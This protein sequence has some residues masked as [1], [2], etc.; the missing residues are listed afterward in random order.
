MGRSAGYNLLVVLGVVSAV[1]FLFHVLPGD[2]ARL[3]MGQRSDEASVANAR[4]ELHLDRNLSVRYLL[5]VND[6]SPIGI[7]GKEERAGG[8]YHFASLMLLGENH[9]VLK[10]PYLGTS[11]RTRRPVIDVLLEALPGTVLLAITALS[12]AAIFGI[13]LGIV[14]ALNNRTVTDRVISTVSVLGISLPSFFAGLLISY[15]FGYVWQRFTGLSMTGSMYEYDP[16]LGR[17]LALDHLILPAFALGL[18]P[19]AIIT[20]LTRSAMLDV[21]TQ[22]YMTTAYAKGLSKTA[23]VLRHALPN[24]LNPVITAVSGWLAD[25]LAGSFFIEYVFGWKG[26]GKITVDALE[27]F[28]FPLVMGSVILTAVLFIAINTL[29]DGLYRIV[30]SRVEGR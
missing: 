8:R 15:L 7:L 22:P 10:T 14:A 19:L 20:Q 29:A 28:D 3:I 25:L 11:Y 12:F 23:A 13:A 17:R 2:P 18:R 27:K 21:L 24:A 1:F 30:D 6:L 4:R 9:I 16:F 26:V 5:F